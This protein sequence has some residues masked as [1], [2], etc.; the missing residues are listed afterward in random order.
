MWEYAQCGRK[1]NIGPDTLYLRSTS[2]TT[3]SLRFNM[4]SDGVA[5]YFAN[6]VLQDVP[7]NSSTSRKLKV[8]VGNLTYSVC[9]DTVNTQ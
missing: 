9:D 3:P 7:L 6:M 8:K 5:D 1:L 4:N 2:R